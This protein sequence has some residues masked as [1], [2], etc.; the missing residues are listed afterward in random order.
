MGVCV[1]DILLMLMKAESESNSKCNVLWFI[2][3][4]GTAA[5]VLLIGYFD[6]LD[7]HGVEDAHVRLLNYPVSYVIF[8]SR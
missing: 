4:T 5:P 2:L 6:S 8:L 7:L 1:S 3:V